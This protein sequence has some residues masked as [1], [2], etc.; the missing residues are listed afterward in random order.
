LLFGAETNVMKL[1]VTIAEPTAGRALRAIA[2]LPAA[3][4]G[5]ELRVDALEGAGPCD[6]ASFRAATPGTLIVTDRSTPGR[7]RPFDPALLQRALEAGADFIDVELGPAN[8]APF[9]HR[10]ASRI[11]LSHHDFDGC[12]D[13]EAL[14]ARMSAT[15]CEHVKIAVT[16]RTFHDNLRLLSAQKE[17]REVKYLTMIGMGERGLYSRILAPFFGARFAFVAPAPAAAAAP[18]QLG[19]DRALAIYGEERD[20]LTADPALFA[21]VGDPASHSRSPLFHNR[22]FRERGLAAAYSIVS[23]PRFEEVLDPLLAGEPLA[24]RG[25]SI[26]APF[27]EEAFAFAVRSGAEIAANAAEC[28]SVNTLVRGDGGTLLADNTDVDAFSAVLAQLC[29]RDR[30]SVALIGAG[31]TS[32]AA[33]VALRRA[34]MHTTIFNRTFARARTLAAELGAFARPLEELARF[35]G[36]IIINT[37]S[38]ALTTLPPSLL[39]AGRAY[40]DVDYSG[41]RAAVL[42]QTRAAG[43]TVIE[44]LEIFTLQAQRQNDLFAQSLGPESSTLSPVT[45]GVS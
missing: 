29:G 15:G 32:R 11:I 26:T 39:R 41:A 9:L 21:I 24:P 38:T 2:A 42:E 43:L 36:E 13:L 18:G 31:G 1:I 12:P 34:G 16:P 20:A 37:A 45:E 3:V 25:I 5:V 7:P 44:G 4:D 27:K 14:I 30:K 40:I 6:F 33:L 35:D 19:L 17:R 8:D 10:Y 22:R 23:T 28:R